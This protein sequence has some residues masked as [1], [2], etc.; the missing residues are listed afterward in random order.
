MIAAQPVLHSVL[1]LADESA[2]W[3]VAGLPQLQRILL[4]VNEYAEASG[5][6]VPVSVC[7]SWQPKLPAASRLVVDDPR[8]TRL[9][10]CECE[11]DGG[12]FDLVLSTRVFLYRNA[13]AAMLDA[14][15]L[16]AAG[17]AASWAERLEDVRRELQLNA[18]RCAQTNWHYLGD[19]AVIPSVERAFLRQNGKSQDGLV[20]R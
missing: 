4:S 10:V 20:S 11:A 9:E 5:Q 1:L 17:I 2:S 18:E 3:R 16:T 14:G 7:V 13:I 8:L 12:S 19:T 15:V 6:T